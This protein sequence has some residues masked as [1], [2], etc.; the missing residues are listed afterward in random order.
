MGRFPYKETVKAPINI[1]LVRIRLV[2]PVE[3]E[4]ETEPHHASNLPHIP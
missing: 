3:W 2:M 4:N 1:Q